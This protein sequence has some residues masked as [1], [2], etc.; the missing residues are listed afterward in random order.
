M[1]DEIRCPQFARLPCENG[2]DGYKT[3]PD[4]AQF[5]YKQE[6][7]RR[8]ISGRKFIIGLFY[9]RRRIK[10]HYRQW[11]F[12][13]FHS[14]HFAKTD[15]KTAT[16]FLVVCIIFDKAIKKLIN[17]WNIPTW[18][19][20]HFFHRGILKWLAEVYNGRHPCLQ[21]KSNLIQCMVVASL[22][23]VHN[24]FAMRSKLSFIQILV[25]LQ[26]IEATV[27]DSLSSF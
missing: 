24:F 13:N 8:V 16:K 12:I 19:W 6:Q 3:D 4:L 9:Q 1:Y 22:K 2:N 23:V 21:M 20:Q 7:I 26:K 10:Q 14:V 11:N 17:S 27:S 5:F 15:N 25:N 18:G